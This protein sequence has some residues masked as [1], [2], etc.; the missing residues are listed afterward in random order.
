MKKKCQLWKKYR[1]DRTLENK[2]L[3]AKQSL[4]VRKLIYDYYKQVEHSVIKETT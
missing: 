1:K 3:Y 4:L 2:G